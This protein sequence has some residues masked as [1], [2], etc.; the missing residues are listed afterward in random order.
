MIYA[1]TYG[2]EKYSMSR[3]ANA[4]TARVFGHADRVIQLG[5]EDIDED[6]KIINKSNQYEKRGGVLVVETISNS[7]SIG[8]N[9]VW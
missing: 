7:S 5:P 9:G 8:E 1:I 6:F 2:D 3:K 4:L